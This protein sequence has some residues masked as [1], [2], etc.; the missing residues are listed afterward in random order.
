[1]EA[2]QAARRYAVVE[3]HAAVAVGLHVLQV[4]AARAERFHHS[5]LGIFLAS[6]VSISYGS[7]FS[8]FTSLITTRGRETRVVAFAAHVLDQDDEMQLARRDSY[9][10]IVGI[11]T[12]KATLLISF[13][14]AALAQLAAGHE[15]ASRPARGGLTW[16]S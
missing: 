10:G 5:A 4:A 6:T 9:V 8:P 2:D 11:D 3:P 16:N 15:L 13:R 7:C 14:A 12:A 1:L